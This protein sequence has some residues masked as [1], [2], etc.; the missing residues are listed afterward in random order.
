MSKK[1]LFLDLALKENT[2]GTDQIK[3]SKL[4]MQPL[5]NTEGIEVLTVCGNATKVLDNETKAMLW[6]QM[7]EMERFPRMIKEVDKRNWLCVVVIY[8]M[9][10]LMKH[11][12]CLRLSCM[13]VYVNTGWYMEEILAT[14]FYKLNWTSI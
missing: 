10:C 8:N 7:P 12:L 9:F 13:C 3:Q 6:L 5:N 4:L 14:D 1:N 2:R 11:I